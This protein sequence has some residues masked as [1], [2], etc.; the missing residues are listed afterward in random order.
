MTSGVRVG[1]LGPVRAWR[2]GTA[3]D[4]GSPRQ[5]ALLACLALDEGR[6]VSLDRLIDALWEDDPAPTVTPM[7]RSYVSRLRGVLGHEH[8]V[9]LG[10]GYALRGVGTDLAEFH[11]LTAQGRHRR[12]LALWRGDPVPELTGRYGQATRTQLDD[13]RL[14]AIEAA[15]EQ[16]LAAGAAGGLVPEL[17]DV[18]ARH[19]LRE[20]PCGLLMRAYAAAGRHAEAQA[21]YAEFQQLLAEE[22]G[23][24]PGPELARLHS[25]LS[26]GPQA[27]VP[28]QL[29]PDIGDFTGRAAQVDELVGELRTERERA[30]VVSVVSGIGGV[31][32]TTL[33]LHV[34]HA[35]RGD[36]PGGQLYVDLQGAGPAPADPV[37][38]LAGFLRALGVGDQEIPDEPQERSALFR[39]IVSGRRMLVVLD[40]A[41]D[42]AQVSPLV[43]GDHGCGVLVTSRVRLLGLD[44][45]RVLDLTV[46]EGDEAVT[47]LAKIIGP[48]RVAAE[49]EQARRLAELCGHLP[50]AVRVAGARLASRGTWTITSMVDR[51]A[52]ERDRLRALRVRDLAVES[53]FELSYRQLDPGCARA[54]RLAAV[55][56]SEDLSLSSA[57]ALLGVDEDEAEEL[58]ENLV[59]LSLLES[60]SAGRYRFHDLLKVYARQQADGEREQALDRLVVHLLA[61][62]QSACEVW[63]L[64][65][66]WAGPREGGG[67]RFAGSPEADRWL[68]AELPGIWPVVA[69]RGDAVAVRLL[70]LLEERVDRMVHQREF[71]KAAEAVKQDA[72][73][74]GDLETAAGAVCVLGSVLFTVGEHAQAEPLLR[75]AAGHARDRIL[76]CEITT[77]LALVIATRLDYPAAVEVALAAVRAGRE[78]GDPAAEARALTNLAQIQ[79]RTD[80]A[81]EALVHIT[82][83]IGLVRPVK[84]VDFEVSI[85]GDVLTAL[86]RHAEAIPCYTEALEAYRAQGLVQMS[87]ENLVLLADAHLRTGQLEQALAQADEAL[88]LSV[89]IEDQVNEARALLARGETLVEL[90]EPDEGQECLRRSL[91]IY[92]SLDITSPRLDRIRASLVAD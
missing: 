19:P 3:L 56:D 21:V 84:T 32:K 29:P 82:A 31:G 69:Q 45:A 48:E 10:G 59:D 17:L 87:V 60:P 38:A 18:V 70:R 34:A 5:R 68:A 86:G 25:G 24:D 92:D 44:G 72:E 64:A 35:V 91:A 15:C 11:T 90:G 58:L 81:E 33:A 27:P 55:P 22:L 39:S 9:R 85:M 83:V 1:V 30:P 7:V 42:A 16:E 43:P 6:P 26:A 61:T 52:G 80:Q 4:L 46:L 2:D 50:L 65:L 88:A 77:L 8:L 78:S 51:L 73:A 13:L 47:L 53:S 75:A 28:A 89:E 49:P 66:Y 41:A 74:R 67:L 79:L 63:R 76:L 20:R 14:T 54:F 12:A 36:F 62:L 40:N 57:A 37:A 71:R 23:I